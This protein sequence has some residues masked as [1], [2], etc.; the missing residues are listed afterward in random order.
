MG[1]TIPLPDSLKT[2]EGVWEGTD[3]SGTRYY[4]AF[5]LGGTDITIIEA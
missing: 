1:N 2:L 5:W 3:A 4:F